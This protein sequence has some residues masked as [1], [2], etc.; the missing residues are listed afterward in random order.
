MYSA[1]KAPQTQLQ[2]TLGLFLLLALI[3]L[4]PSLRA[5]QF[6]DQ[7][8]PLKTGLAFHMD[9]DLFVGEDLDKDY[10]GGVALTFS[11]RQAVTSP[12]SLD[13]V[14]A[15]LDR[16]LRF[17]SLY[18]SEQK[19]KLHALEAGFVLFTPSDLS[20]EAPLPEDHPYA[21]LFFLVNSQQVVVPQQQ[22]AFSSVFTLGALGLDIAEDVHAGTHDATGSSPPMGWSNQISSGGEI[23]A[24]YSLGV[25]KLVSQM[26]LPLN[27]RGEFK[28]AAEGNMGFTTG[29]GVGFSARIGRIHTPW[30][31]FNPQQ[32]D[33][34]SQGSPIAKNYSGQNTKDLFFYFGA[35]VNYRFY[36]AILQ[37][38]FR[39]SAVTY[40]S[41]EINSGNVEL[42]AGVSHQVTRNW[43]VGGF[44]RSRT[45]DLK[46][47]EDDA[48]WGGLTVSRSM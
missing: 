32:S 19:L 4:A 35:N 7:Q 26:R 34:A 39:E 23:T 37:G 27:L 12:V 46:N 42:W 25:Q 43:N 33:Y 44:V 48:L 3:V 30:W 9:N 20:I 36:N 24:R 41:D 28:L 31:G 13:G 6:F 15:R 45:A 14:R 22:L 40:N 5:Q 10:T 16:I 8:E 47:A 11:G 1:T 2:P 38:Q 17:S 21:S 29:A 18:D